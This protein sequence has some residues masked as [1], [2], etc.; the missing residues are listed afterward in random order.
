MPESKK[1][2]FSNNQFLRICF[3]ILAVV[4]LWFFPRH[5]L[6]NP[7]TTF[8][9]HKY[10]L[11]FQ[12]PLCGMTRAVYQIT[13]FQIASA[14]SYNTVAIMLPFYFLAD[15]SS[16]LFDKNWMARARKIIMILIFIGLLLLYLYRMAMHFHWI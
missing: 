9:P 12:C 15:V 2:S 10:F 4:A 1:I 11:G 13:H 7:S 5:L 8:C 14:I 3:L 16:F 6:F